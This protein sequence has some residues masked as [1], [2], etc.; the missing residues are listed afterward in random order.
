MS[1]LAHQLRAEQRLYWRSRELAFFAFL[2][3]ILIFVLL[4]SVYGDERIESEGGVRGSEYLLAG[5]LGYGLASTAFAGLAIVLVARRE[6]GVLKRLRGTP[7]PPWAYLA[8]V[9]GSTVAVFA[10]EAVVLVVL[11]NLL[12]DVP[13]PSTV[14]SLAVALLLGAL[15]F[16][17]LGM[18][19]TTVIRSAE[20]ASAVVNA[21]YLPA[22]FLSGSFW[23]PH[24]YPRFLEVIAD[25]L[26]LTYFIRLMR[27][28]VVHED[29]IWSHPGALLYVLAWGVAGVIV[30]LRSFR[31]QP[32]EG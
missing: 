2:F 12:F 9:L 23:T 14:P 30:C 5:M 13:I 18:A 31:W 24:A 3:P 29:Q 32:H 28:I 19:L 21:I 26:P 7:L 17:A 4:G 8:A 6:D 1:V 10:L 11:G 22:A 16:S 25:V 20:G 27:D 15:V